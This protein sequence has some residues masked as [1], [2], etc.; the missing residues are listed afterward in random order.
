MMITFISRLMHKYTSKFVYL[1]ISRLIKVNKYYSSIWSMWFEKRTYNMNPVLH[2]E[3]RLHSHHS[4]KP[5]VSQTAQYVTLWQKQKNPRKFLSFLF[6]FIL[7]KM[8]KIN[9]HR[10]PCFFLSV[11]LLHELPDITSKQ[12]LWLCIKPQTTNGQSSLHCRH[13]FCHLGTLSSTGAHFYVLYFFL[14]W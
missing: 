1:C 6:S 4:F 11:T 14:W 2:V 7:P 13:L 10:S 12:W 3:K 9:A 5:C 8:P